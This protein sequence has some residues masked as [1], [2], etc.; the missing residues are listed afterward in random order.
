M[1]LRNLDLLEDLR[2]ICKIDDE[3]G[4]VIG[5]WRYSF[6]LVRSDGETPGTIETNAAYS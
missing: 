3:A 1:T 4:V 5:H 6:T 2:E